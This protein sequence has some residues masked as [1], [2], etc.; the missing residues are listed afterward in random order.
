MK[1]AANLLPEFEHE[2]ALTRKI[3][4]RVPN[5][6]L[7]WTP[8]PKSYPLRNLS[9]HLANLPSWTA[10]T[11]DQPQLDLDSTP[12]VLPIQD[13]AMALSRFDANAAAALAS[14]EGASDA[15][16]MGPW[17]LIAGGHKVFTLP[18][19]AVLRSFVM[20]HMIH[21][22]GQLSVY[23]RLCDVPLPALYGPTADESK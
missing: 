3:L 2:F 1:I 12:H 5:S 16:L 19:V 6:R 14:I 9:T 18:K 20:N 7:D 4:E 15:T 17:S 8:H 23:L 13:V 22:R 10:A 11:I 21:H